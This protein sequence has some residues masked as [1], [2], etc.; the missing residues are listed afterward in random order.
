MLA[1]CDVAA[2]A[3]AARLC[4]RSVAQQGTEV[5][6]LVLTRS[7]AQQHRPGCRPPLWAQGNAFRDQMQDQ[8]K[9]MALASQERDAA[10]ARCA[11]LTVE[12]LLSQRAH[13]HRPSM[14]S[15]GWRARGV[16]AAAGVQPD[17]P[18]QGS[19]DGCLRAQTR[20]APGQ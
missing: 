19:A 14:Q 7:V 15:A 18:W 12:G 2:A 20:G 16:A 4:Q 8:A 1:G 11:S 5:G 9:L 17:C 3:D 10:V 13:G 6:N